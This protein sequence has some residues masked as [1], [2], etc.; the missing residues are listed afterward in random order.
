MLVRGFRFLGILVE[1]E[2]E[3]EEGGRRGGV[4]RMDLKSGVWL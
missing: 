3:G 2:G 1:G 4:G